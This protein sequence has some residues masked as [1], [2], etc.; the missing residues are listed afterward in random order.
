MAA[1]LNYE[2]VH[3]LH[4]AGLKVKDLARRFK[5]TPQSIYNALSRYRQKIGRP[6]HLSNG[7]AAKR[8]ASK[9][10]HLRARMAGRG[11]G[12][13]VSSEIESLR[14]KRDTITQ[15]MSLLEQMG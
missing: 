3:A 10:P 11:Q 9:V 13:L 14:K 15:A 4:E 6:Q 7:T 1:K 12:S 2:K 8:G 5:T